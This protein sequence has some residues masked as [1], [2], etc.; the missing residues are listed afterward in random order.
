MNDEEKQ[1]KMMELQIM[2]Q[3]SE[4]L[5]Q[6]LAGLEE[7]MANLRNLEE[8]LSNLEKEKVGKNMYTPLSSGVFVKARLE[9]NKE[10]LVAVGAGV[11]VKKNV[12]EARSMLKD[13]E[14]KME[15]VLMQVKGEFEKYATSAANIEHELSQS[16]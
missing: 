16:Q 11:V 7:Q 15:L 10:V 6:Q 8:S 4:Q 13:Q 2:N 3:Q 9:D 1:Q 5:R 14:K 12:K